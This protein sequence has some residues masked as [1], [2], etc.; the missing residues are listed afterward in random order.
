MAEKVWPDWLPVRDDLRGESP[1]GAP[2]LDVTVRL[3]TNENPYALPDVVVAEVEREIS[4]VAIGL[5]RYPDR[6]EIE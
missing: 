1:Y 2:Q 3:N 4:K 5:N 6:D